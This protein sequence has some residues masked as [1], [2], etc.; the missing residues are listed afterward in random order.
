MEQFS[1]VAK[2]H[3]VIPEVEKPIA[4]RGTYLHPEAYVITSYSIHYTKLY[5]G[6]AKVL[7]DGSDR[8]PVTTVAYG[9][10]VLTPEY[11]SPEQLR[12]GTITTAS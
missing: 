3:P 1:Q 9:H 4:E 12:G 6:I 10:R 8:G 5:D 2:M 7:G 11:A